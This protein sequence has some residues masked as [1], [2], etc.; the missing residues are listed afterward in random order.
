MSFF[1]KIFGK[2][3]NKQATM[4]SASETNNKEDWDFYFTNV[5]GNLA[6]I[7]VDLGLITMAPMKDKPNIVWVSIQMNNPREDGLSSKEESTL[8]CDIEDAL[9][10]KV[11]S[12]HNSIYIGRLT[13]AGH[14][15]LYFYS[16]DTMLYDRTISE[17]MVS[18]PKYEFEYGSKEDKEWSGYLDFLYPTP[19]QM[20]TIQNRRVIDQLEK[21]GDDLTKAREVDHWIYFKTETDREAY[22]EQISNNG[23]SIV[24]KGYNKELDE[25]PFVLHIKR[26]DNVDQNSVD[27]YVIY[28]WKLANELNADYDGWETSI[29]KDAN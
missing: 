25:T 28:L 9:V 7:F 1:N 5:D 13:S 16:G 6:S 20:Q 22:I 14:R 26:M 4:L 29:E 15:D 2:P 19:T 21:N 24:E 10:S 27:D 3:N 11:S 17:V 8:L 18:Y 23:F 12:K